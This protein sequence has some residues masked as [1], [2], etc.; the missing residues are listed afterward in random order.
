MHVHTKY[1]QLACGSSWIGIPRAWYWF[2]RTADPTFSACFLGPA[3]RP[4]TWLK[5]QHFGLLG[6]LLRGYAGLVACWSRTKP[7][8]K[9]L[10]QGITWVFI[11][12]A[13]QRS[14]LLRIQPKCNVERG[15]EK[16]STEN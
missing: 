8:P 13:T 7:R 5:M 16:K 2:C 10:P 11:L 15:L 1:Y 4:C 14:T 6:I 12:F 3:F 9:A